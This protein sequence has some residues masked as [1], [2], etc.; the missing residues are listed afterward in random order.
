[1]PDLEETS[2]EH[3]ANIRGLAAAFDQGQAPG[4]SLHELK[5]AGA[6]KLT[7]RTTSPQRTSNKFNARA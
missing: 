6:D 2:T 3:K 5:Q 4:A 7:I 1:M